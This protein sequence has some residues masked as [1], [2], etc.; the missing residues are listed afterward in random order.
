V[1]RTSLFL[2]AALATPGCAALH[3]IRREQR[4]DAPVY[5]EVARVSSGLEL[6]LEPG[7][8]G[9]VLSVAE[10]F[11]CIEEAT[12]RGAET[13]HARPKDAVL[14]IAGVLAGA[15]LAGGIAVAGGAAVDAVLDRGR[16]DVNRD[17]PDPVLRTWQQ[18]RSTAAHVAAVGLGVAGVGTQVLLSKKIAEWLKQI[19]YEESRPARRVL[20]RKVPCDRVL[21]SGVLRGPRLPPEGL[22]LGPRGVAPPG[23]LPREGL[24]LDGA[25]VDF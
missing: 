6:Q 5:V 19:S 7:D 22:R 8:A 24:T 20:G 2:L 9:V 18:P 21:K 17:N 14:A 3:D 16:D 25:P 1:S 13:V 15:A 10:R 12:Q 4:W 11:D 23:F